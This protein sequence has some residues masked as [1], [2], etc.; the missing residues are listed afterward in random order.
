MEF[1]NP[2]NGHTEEKSA[3]WFW[4]LLFGG[5]YLVVNGAWAPALIWLLIGGVLYG[6]MGAP[7][8]LLMFV[9]GIVYATLANGIIRNTYLR[10]GWI[11]V[12]P[13]APLEAP[14]TKKCPACAE[15]IKAEATVCRYC[16]L[17]Q[18][19]SP[20]PTTDTQESKDAAIMGQ[21]GVTL[22]DGMYELDGR[23]FATLGQAIKYANTVA[24]ATANNR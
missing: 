12:D 16:N 15:T 11:E 2:T 7:A 4:T 18:P 17:A 6:A 22:A 5:I 20:E 13:N 3:P 1:K 23:H 14:D 24:F 10:K 8:T 19:K 9:V 21:H